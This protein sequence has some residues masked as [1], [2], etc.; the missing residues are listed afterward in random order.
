M[1]YNIDKLK[2]LDIMQLNITKHMRSSIKL[3]VFLKVKVSLIE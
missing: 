2:F 3:F 1:K